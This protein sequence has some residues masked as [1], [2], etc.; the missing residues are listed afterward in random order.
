[1]EQ[2]L[3]EARIYPMRRELWGKKEGKMEG[4]KGGETVQLELVGSSS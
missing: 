3:C 1:M 2:Y 4:Q